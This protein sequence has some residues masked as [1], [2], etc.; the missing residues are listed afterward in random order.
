[1]LIYFGG[2]AKT[3]MFSAVH[4]SSAPVISD[5]LVSQLIWRNGIANPAASREKIYCCTSV[6]LDPCSLAPFLGSSVATGYSFLAGRH[7]LYV[8]PS[9][10]FR[11]RSHTMQL[12]RLTELLLGPAQNMRQTFSIGIAPTAN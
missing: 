4:I 6:K 9:D 2:C 12:L 10:K 8:L 11:I 7:S 1:M 3:T 5:A